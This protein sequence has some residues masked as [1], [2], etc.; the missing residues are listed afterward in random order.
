MHKSLFK[1]SLKNQSIR[2]VKFP[3]AFLLVILII[4]NKFALIWPGEH[5]QTIHSILIPKSFIWSPISIYHFST[6][7]FHI[8]F[9]ISLINTKLISQFTITIPFIIFI[10]SF[11]LMAIRFFF[12]FNFFPLFKYSLKVIIFFNLYSFT[13]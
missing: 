5:S 12:A 1:L 3:I 2:P 4:S 9:K 6:S 13:L 10:V 11:I 7:I 8:I